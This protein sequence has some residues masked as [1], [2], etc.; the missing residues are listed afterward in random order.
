MVEWSMYNFQTYG[1]H[2]MIYGYHGNQLNTMHRW[3]QQHINESL[4]LSTLAAQPQG[5][6][7]LSEEKTVPLRSAH[8]EAYRYSIATDAT[9]ISRHTDIV[10]NE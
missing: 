3:C 1:S 9:F 4:S 5:R 6:L 10:R 7:I 2:P 8:R